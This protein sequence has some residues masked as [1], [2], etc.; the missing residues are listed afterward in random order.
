MDG[1]DVNDR[2]LYTRFHIAVSDISAFLADGPFEWSEAPCDLIGDV[3]MEFDHSGGQG[4]QIF[5]VLDRCG[6]SV[7][8]DQVCT[9]ASRRSASCH[10][11]RI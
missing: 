4:R 7:V 9:G 5:P 1:K 8:L 6:M 2:V 11:L 3:D 10:V